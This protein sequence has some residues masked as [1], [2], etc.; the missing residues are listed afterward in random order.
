MKARKLSLLKVVVIAL[1]AAGLASLGA[2]DRSTP[3]RRKPKPA[4]TE[5]APAATPAPQAAP[6]KAPLAPP[7]A[8][9]A[10]TPFAPS[11]PAPMPM[12]TPGTPPP[13]PMMTPAA[14]PAAPT[15][16]PTTV[17]IAE[18][19]FDAGSVEKGTDIKHEFVLKNVGEN[20]LMV[21]AKPG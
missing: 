10:A 11:S 17:E 6:A 1:A 3:G 9:P 13:M 20:P 19:S 8:T 16:P 2:A 5:A 18:T 15:G 14:A 4:T 12:M 21:D 7:A